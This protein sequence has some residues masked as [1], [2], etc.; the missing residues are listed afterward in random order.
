MDRKNELQDWHI[1]RDFTKMGYKI[2]TDAIQQNIIP[3]L[4]L[5]KNKEYIIYSSEA[6]SLNITVFGMKAGEFAKQNPKLTTQGK[7]IRDCASKKAL[8]VI[9]NLRSSN[10]TMIREGISKERRAY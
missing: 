8:N 2:Q 5:P 10:A 1:F 3:V 9:N 7:N 6:D 4:N